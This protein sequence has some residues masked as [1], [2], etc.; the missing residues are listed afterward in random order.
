MR[1]LVDMED[2]HIRELDRLAE[3]QNRSRAALIREAIAGY[4]QT[5]AQDTAENA[6]GLWGKKQIDGLAYQAKIR[7]E[8]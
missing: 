4:L 7:G 1:A 2:K 5:Q 3:K 6:F 8:W